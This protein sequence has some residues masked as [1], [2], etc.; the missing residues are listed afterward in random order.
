[1]LYSC[2]SLVGLSLVVFE[3]CWPGS[4]NQAQLQIFACAG[5]NIKNS[6]AGLCISLL[7]FFTAL[8]PLGLLYH[9]WCYSSTSKY[10]AK[11]SIKNMAGSAEPSS[12]A[13]LASKNLVV[14]YIGF[15]CI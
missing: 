15:S 3:L 2:I 9:N 4:L 12:T 13:V 11:P 10:Q 7:M 1:M 6:T 8:K 14:E 5:F